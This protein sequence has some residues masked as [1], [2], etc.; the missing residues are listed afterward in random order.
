MSEDFI[1][2]E[3]LSAN[4]WIR[5]NQKSRMSAIVK[6]ISTADAKKLKEDLDNKGEVPVPLDDGSFFR[7]THE[8]VIFE[9]K[10]NPGY[11]AAAGSVGVVILHSR[12]QHV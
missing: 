10:P 5:H 8:H 12:K 1:G 7:L 11:A 9:I 4:E 6:F 2:I 3:P